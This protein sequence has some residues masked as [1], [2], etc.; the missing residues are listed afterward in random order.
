M[1]YYILGVSHIPSIIAMQAY[2]LCHIDRGLCQFVCVCLCVYVFIVLIK[3]FQTNRSAST[4]NEV[5]PD[6]RQDNN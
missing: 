3:T 6:F 4:P 2:N 5:L 1:Q